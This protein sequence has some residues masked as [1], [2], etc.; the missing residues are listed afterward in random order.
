MVAGWRSPPAGNA[1]RTFIRDQLDDTATKS[2]RMLF[3]SGV[4]DEFGMNFCYVHGGT[5][6]LNTLVQS[7]TEVQEIKYC[8]VVSI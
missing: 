3:R 7:V 1:E 4:E 8:Y 6:L 5:E 2:T